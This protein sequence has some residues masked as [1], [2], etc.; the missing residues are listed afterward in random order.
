MGCCVEV[1]TRASPAKGRVRLVP[2]S[3]GSAPSGHAEAAGAAG[4]RAPPRTYL[5][6]PTALA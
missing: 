6:Q 4:A 1:G 5:G 2:G 3:S